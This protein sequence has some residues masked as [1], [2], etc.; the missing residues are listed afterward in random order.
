VRAK[1]QVI[2]EMGDQIVLIAGRPL[3]AVGTT[4]TVLVHTVSQSG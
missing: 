2:D 3:G 1:A 4:N